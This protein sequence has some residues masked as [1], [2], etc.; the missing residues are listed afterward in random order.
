MVVG[1]LGEERG[2]KLFRDIVATNGLSVRKG[3]TMLTNLA[4]AGEV[5]IGLTIYLQNAEVARKNGAAVDWFPIAPIVAK[6]NGVAVARRT[7]HPH[8]ALLFYDFMIGEG[9]QVMLK[10]EFLPTSRKIPSVLDRLA[11]NFVDPAIV[12]DSSAKWQKLYAEVVRSGG[13]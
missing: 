13:R 9:Q 1:L 6:P 7:P 11:L 3:H 4:A 2:L 12:L 8:A 10:R 5:P